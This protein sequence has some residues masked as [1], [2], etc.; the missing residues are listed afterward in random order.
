M[1]FA[2]LLDQ[3]GIPYITEGHH[4]CRAGWLQMDCPFCGKG[5]GKYHMGYSIAGNYAAC[6]R[7]GGHSLQS[8]LVEFLHISYERAKEL[9]KGL[10]RT[11]REEVE[12]HVGTLK[13]PKGVKPMLPQ[14]RRYI[15]KERRMDPDEIERLW[16]VQGIGIAARLSWRL[17]IPI[18]YRGEVVSWT[19]RSISKDVDLRYV[20]ASSDEEA[21]P[22]KTLLYGEDMVRHACCIVEGPLDAWKIGPGAVATCGT[23]YSRAQ[24]LR[25]TRF[26][27]RYVCFDNEPEAQKRARD[28][29]NNLSAF[30]GQ[31][32]NVT[33]DA[34]DAAEASD[35]EIAQLRRTL[36]L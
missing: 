1:K 34:K 16:H 11:K 35:E 29:V 30:P 23:G 25:M 3:T 26:L 27:Y 28:L 17:F 22:H 18:E 36:G 9:L 6:W 33:L 10:E 15:R 32:F 19:T 21:V 12:E 4:H 2:E 31:T 14:H 7:C 8:I 20:S 24:F 13:V 5:S